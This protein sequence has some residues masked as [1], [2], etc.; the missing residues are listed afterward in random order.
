VWLDDP[1]LSIASQMPFIF[2][3]ENCSFEM[4][5]DRFKNRSDVQNPVVRQIS[6]QCSSCGAAYH[7]DK[8]PQSDRAALTWTSAFIK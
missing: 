2:E 7:Y 5:N 1:N 6:L 3:C 8:T 4:D